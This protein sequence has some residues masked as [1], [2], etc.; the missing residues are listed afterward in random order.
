MQIPD[1][2]PERRDSTPPLPAATRPLPLSDGPAPLRLHKRA[3]TGR[4]RSVVANLGVVTGVLATALF[5]N[6]F[7]LQ[8]YYVD[9]TSM[10]PT[11][12][13]NDRLLIDKA[14]WSAARLTGQAYVPERGDVVIINSA[15]K[16]TNGQLEQLIKRVIALPGER[17]VINNGKATVYNQA[18]PAGF[19]PDTSLGLRLDPT[20][21]SSD[22][23]KQLADDE[24][25]VM[26]DNRSPGGSLDSR[27]FGPVK[28][29][30]LDG[31]LLIR[32]YPF[33]QHFLF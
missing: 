6:T 16:D 30:A 4:L 31:K 21:A 15:I 29:T 9:G 25:F 12:H 26:G 14:E 7:V 13:N 23:D 24:I 33:D 18:N 11:L 2:L 1:R 8:S 28:L 5:I 3:R 20:F 10:A 17:I 27:V 32:V 19:D 22:I